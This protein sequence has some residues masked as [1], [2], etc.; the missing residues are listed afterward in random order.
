M[1]EQPT[2]VSESC[3]TRWGHQFMVFSGGYAMDRPELLVYF[4]TGV[5]VIAMSCY[6]SYVYLPDYIRHLMGYVGL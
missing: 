5:V 4:A 2:K 3:F 1:S 6:S